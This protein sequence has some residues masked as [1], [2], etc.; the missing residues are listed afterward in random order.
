MIRIKYI[1]WFS[2]INN[3]LSIKSSNLELSREQFKNKKNKYF[4]KFKTNTVDEQFYVLIKIK[5]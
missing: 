5:N 1:F 2:K 4:W 3:F